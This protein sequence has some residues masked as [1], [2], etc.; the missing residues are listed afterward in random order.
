[1][2]LFAKE[3]ISRGTLV[4]EFVEG[5]DRYVSDEA[6]ATL[7]HSALDFIYFY[8]Y[9]S[10][11]TGQY[12]FLGDNDRFTNHSY[13]PNVGGPDSLFP[14]R[15]GGAALRDIAAGEEL[16]SDYSVFDA[17]FHLYSHL[18]PR[19]REKVLVRVNRNKKT[20]RQ[21]MSARVRG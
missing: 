8:F 12:V 3:P 6:M 2:G 13:N 20:S 21:A 10:K 14:H 4:W 15:D 17:D 11:F 16:T 9:R 1:M 18:Y 5:I 19:E 7:P